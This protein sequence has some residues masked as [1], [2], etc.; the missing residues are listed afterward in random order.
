MGL[1]HHGQ[2]PRMGCWEKRDR[3]WS[4]TMNLSF[5]GGAKRHS[6]GDQNNSHFFLMDLEAGCPDQGAGLFGSW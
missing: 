2:V 1:G 3:L 5:P 4:H 6:L